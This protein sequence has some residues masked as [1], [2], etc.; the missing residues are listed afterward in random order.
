[1]RATNTQ[2]REIDLKQDIFDGLKMRIRGPLF[3]PGDVGYEESRTVWN[4][5]IDRKPAV[6]VRALAVP[7]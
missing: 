1:M 6:V 7:T 2:G 3:L 4:A 5:M